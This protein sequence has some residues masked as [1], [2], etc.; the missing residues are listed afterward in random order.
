MRFDHVLVALAIAMAAA[1]CG[2]GGGGGGGDD[3]DGDGD[4][5]DAGPDDGGGDA[6]DGADGGDSGDDGDA[7]PGCGLRTCALAGATCG[8]IGDGCGD[9]IQCGECEGTETCGGG[10]TPSVCGGSSACIPATCESAGATCG[11]IGDGCGGMIA[12]CGTCGEDSVCGGDAIP[13]VCSTGNGPCLEGLCQDQ[14]DC[15]PGAPTSLSGTVFTPA[16]NLPLYNVTVYVPD[17]PLDAIAS[18][19]E[20]CSTCDAPVSGDPL[21]LTTTDALGNFVL[22]DVPA[23]VDFPLVI[24]TG[25]WRRMVTI[26]AVTQCQD[27][28]VA[29]DLT[30]FPRTQGEGGV[31]ENNIPRIALTTGGADA[32]ECLMRKIGIADTEFTPQA[33]AGRVNLYA[34]HGGTNRYRD[35]F[36]VPGAGAAFSTAASLWDDALKLND[37]DMVVLSCEGALDFP[38]GGDASGGGN[39]ANPGYRDGDDLAAM[40]GYLDLYGGRV[41]GS[42]WHHSWVEHGPAPMPTVATITHRADLP[43]PRTVSVNKDD[44]AFPKGAALAEWLLNVAAS[45]VLGDLSLTDGQHTVDAVNPALAQ[46]WISGTN[47]NEANQAG[48]QYFS[49]NT[50]IEVPDDEKCGRMVVTDIH[51]S[52]GDDSGTAVGLRFPNGCTSGGLLPEEKALIFLLFDLA[53]CVTTDLPECTPESCVDAGAQCGP[54][55]DGCGS[56]IQCGSCEEPDT[57]GGAGT[58]NQCGNDG[59]VSTSC[60]AQ[61]AECGAIADGC[62]G[63]LECGPCP[64]NETCGGGGHANECGG[65]VN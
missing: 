3:G 9:I 5:G 27:T 39:L 42:H 1:A 8:P 58:P 56:L 21:V 10:G 33:G 4:G 53:S 51:V 26:P 47:P 34:G 23:G 31:T 52:A 64:E 62:G 63:T 13:S 45:L 30:R 46:T 60:E 12:S 48:V 40:K 6:G 2:G 57:C 59:C 54:V 61:E 18:G 7:G 65:G 22:E 14:V 15:S 29:A 16:G 37:Y 43:K 32:L 49:F 25:K 44:P 17:G 41:F 50:P 11:P 19:N 24:Q 55:A 36:N 20:T 35:N 38:A 28:A